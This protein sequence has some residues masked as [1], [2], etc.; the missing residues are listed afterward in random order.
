V[1]EAYAELDQ[2]GKPGEMVPLLADEITRF[3]SVC[4]AVI[5]RLEEENHEFRPPNPV[6]VEEPE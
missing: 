5:V 2:G 6:G 4:E 3:A 1:D